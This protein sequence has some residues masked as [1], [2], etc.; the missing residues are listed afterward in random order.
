MAASVAVPCPS[1][2]EGLRL[3]HSLTAFQRALPGPAS[4]SKL[5]GVWQGTPGVM[6]LKTLEVL[7]PHGHGIARRTEQ[8]IGHLL[9]LHYETLCVAL[10]KLKQ[11]GHIASE[12]GLSNDNPEAEH[13]RLKPAGRRPPEKGT[14]DR[15]RAVAIMARFLSLEQTGWQ[16]GD[17]SGGC[18]PASRG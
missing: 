13:Y 18:E 14:R 3:N 9:P 12:W 11:E 8:T 7:A 6:L 4:E 1:R 2:A 10:P 16:D 5:T 17:S 15:D